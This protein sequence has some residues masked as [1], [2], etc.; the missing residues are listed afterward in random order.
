MATI[1]ELMRAGSR[2]I[3]LPEMPEGHRIVASRSD[4]FVLY[5]GDV[6]LHLVWMGVDEWHDTRWERCDGST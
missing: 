6:R 5:D 2:A 1:Q 4:V 3:R